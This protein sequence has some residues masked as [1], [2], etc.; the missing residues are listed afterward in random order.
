MSNPLAMAP[1]LCIADD[2]FES[3]SEL[4]G[5]ILV[6]SGIAT[7]LQATLGTRLVLVLVMFLF[8]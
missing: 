5:T 1:F 7:L 4:M 2:D 8:S 6:V 3:K